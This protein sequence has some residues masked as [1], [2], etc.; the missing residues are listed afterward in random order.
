MIGNFIVI[1]VIILLDR[2]NE[3]Y[4]LNR[5]ARPGKVEIFYFYFTIC[6]D[7]FRA[8]D[9]STADFR[10]WSVDE[11]QQN[12]VIIQKIRQSA[13]NYSKFW[14]CILKA[15]KLMNMQTIA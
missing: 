2:V 4:V 6:G 10:N 14:N 3:N 9:T 11:K 8:F 7:I 12:T 13:G 5:Q 15:A 1:R